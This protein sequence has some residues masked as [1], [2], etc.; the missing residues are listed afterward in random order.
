MEEIRNSKLSNSRLLIDSDVIID[1]LRDIG[2]FND[3]INGSAKNIC[4]VSVISLAE[5]YSILYF[6][7]YEIVERLFLQLR[8]I[9]VDSIIARLAGSYRMNF[10]KSHSLTIPDAIIAATAK[11]NNTILITRNL[12]HF[13]MDDIE[14]IRPY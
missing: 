13:P 10:F 8:T 1:H 5:I 7:E 3:L 11:I 9:N 2:N 12:K 6:N 4:Y 14:K